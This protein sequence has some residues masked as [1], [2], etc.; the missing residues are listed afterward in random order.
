MAA[1]IVQRLPVAGARG[2]DA[3]GR[4]A[5]SSTRAR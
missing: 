3:D 2:G 4:H 5:A 1:L